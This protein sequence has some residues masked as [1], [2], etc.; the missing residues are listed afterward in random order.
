MKLTGKIVLSSM[1]GHARKLLGKIREAHFPLVLWDYAMEWRALIYQVTPKNLFQLNGTKPY[2]AT[3]GN[4]ADI[5]HICQ[6][7]WYHWVYCWEQ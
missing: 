2:T 6:F 1:L 5:P 4:E 7:G 3:F